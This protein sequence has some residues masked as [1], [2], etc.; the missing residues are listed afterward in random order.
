[1][2]V[3][4]HLTWMRWALNHGGEGDPGQWGQQP[5]HLAVRHGSKKLIEVLLAA[6]ANHKAKDS[7]RS[8]RQAAELTA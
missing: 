8:Q 2:L 3:Q 7:V 4:T 5:L 6:G 1:M